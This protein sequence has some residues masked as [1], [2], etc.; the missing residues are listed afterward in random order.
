MFKF[1]L[2]FFV[3]IL[4]AQVNITDV[5]KSDLDFLSSQIKEINEPANTDTIQFNSNDISTIKIESNEIL[6]KSEETYYG[7]NFFLR[8]LNFVDN[9][10]AP[11]NYLL[12]PGDKV[13]VYLWGETNI[14]KSFLLDRSGAIF[15]E[16]VGF[17]NLSN[18]SLIQA[19][20]LVKNKLLD[21]YSTLDPSVGTTSLQLEIE[22]PQSINIFFTGQVN[23]PGI[24]IV[25]P[26]ADIF[27][28]IVQAGGVNIN[29]S[30]RQV[31]HIRENKIINKIDFYD[32]LSSGRKNFSDIKLM[33][34]DI[35]NFPVIENRVTLRGAVLNNG[36]FEFKNE[37]TISD[38]LQFSNSLKYDYSTDILVNRILGPSERAGNESAELFLNIDLSDISTFKLKNGD[39]IDFRST[40]KFKNSVEIS[41]PVK[42]PGFYPYDNR[43]LKDILDLAGGFNDINYRKSLIEEIKISRKDVSK[44]ENQE[45]IVSYSDSDSFMLEAGDQVLVYGNTDYLYNNFYKINGQ[46]KKS[47]KYDYYKDI[48]IGD[49][50]LRAGGLTQVA[51]SKSIKVTIDGKTVNNVDL[52]TKIPLNAAINISP[53]SNTIN[54][55]GNISN[56]GL[57]TYNPKNTISDYIKNA[58]GLKPKTDKK[59]LY[60][61]SGSSSYQPNFLTRNFKRLNSGDQ[62]IIPTKND[63]FEINE[64]LSDLSTALSNV[65]A[66]IF[67]IDR[68]NN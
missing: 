47:G 34:D 68:A 8:D 18:K 31:E 59:N 39:I 54:I 19:E 35:I 1:I 57:Y 43:S 38:I 65:L 61:I 6:P 37:E 25:H 66:I 62:I 56:P 28:A 11:K 63:D 49:A 27:T 24:H 29:G 23:N 60:V 14:S 4:N 32:F 55:L 13:V 22:E 10:P 46:I 30:L 20:Q 58:G 44:E 12:G 2:L 41:G 33:N 40:P 21:I 9:L 52:N 3:C 17:I 64:F 7:Y 16:G 51:D 50:I 26:F 36:I 53:K 42:F 15:Y 48:T 45:F 67:I 5:T